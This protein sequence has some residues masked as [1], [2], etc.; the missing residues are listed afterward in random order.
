MQ[1][2][3]VS[4]AELG[5]RILTV[6]LGLAAGLAAG[7]VFDFPVHMFFGTPGIS[8][9]CVSPLERSSSRVGKQ[10]GSCSSSHIP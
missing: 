1:L 4:W 3:W 8:G 7:V 6:W 10:G 5:F 2:E 9:Q